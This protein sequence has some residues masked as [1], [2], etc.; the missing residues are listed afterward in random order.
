MFGNRSNLLDDLY[1]TSP[2]TDYTNFLVTQLDAVLG[3]NGGVVTFSFECLQASQ[4]RDIMF[5][6]NAG[7]WKEVLGTSSLAVFRGDD[8]LV[9]LLI[10][11][12]CRHASV[13]PTVLANI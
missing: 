13:E 10:K 3:P 11:L 8:P 7:A 12:G 5:G 9:L 4:W 1:T 2:S 6:G